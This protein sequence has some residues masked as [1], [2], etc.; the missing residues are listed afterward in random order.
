MKAWGPLS[1]L[2]LDS[3]RID[4]YVVNGNNRSRVIS[5]RPILY[6]VIDVFS[7]MVV[8]FYLGIENASWNSMRKALLNSMTSKVEFCK[9]YDI[10]IN[11]KIGPHSIYQEL[12]FPIMDPK[13]L[14]KTLII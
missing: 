10:E 6:L 9:L 1:V 14:V 2:E 8:G 11:E 5:K 12:Y 13:C 7:R 3:T 4:L